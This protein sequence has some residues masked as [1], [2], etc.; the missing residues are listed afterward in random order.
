[1][2][3][4][5]GIVRA[6]FGAGVVLI[7]A[8]VLLSPWPWVAPI[9]GGVGCVWACYDLVEVKDGGADGDL[10]RVAPPRR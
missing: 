2:V 10:A 5:V 8:G 6:L 9:V 4:R 3:R 1:M 7:V